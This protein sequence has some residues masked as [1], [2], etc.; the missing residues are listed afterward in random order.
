MEE[1]CCRMQYNSRRKVRVGMALLL[2]AALGLGGCSTTEAVSFFSSFFT[3]QET[4]VSKDVELVVE[5]ESVSDYSMTQVFLGEVTEYVTISC[6]YSQT[7][8]I[9]LYFDVDDEII[10]NVYVEKGDTVKKGQL[11][12]SVDVESMETTLKSLQHQLEAAELTLKQ[13]EDSKAFAIELAEMLYTYTYQTTS[14]QEDLADK[15][16][17]INAQYADQLIDAQDNVDILTARVAQAQSYIDAGGLYAPISGVLSMVRDDLEGSLS[18]RTLCVMRIYDADSCMYYSDDVEAAQYIDPDEEYTI[19]CG[20]G[21][22]IAYYT[23]QAANVSS[24]GEKVYFRLLDEEY[25]SNNMVKGKISLPMETKENVLCL[26]YRAVHT[27]DDG[28]FVYIL[29]ED[30]V[31]RMCYIEIGLWGDEY[32]EVLSGLEEGDYVIL[33]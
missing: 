23:V 26:N 32:V 25:D 15:I 31:R 30:N 4:S 5:T 7:V 20:L 29:D 16:E 12:A 19:T 28:Y 24:W 14:D 6:V 9:E 3:A 22:N 21:N 2:A 10:T 17:S 18:D 11:L 13:L 27:T 1:R 33:K 8:E